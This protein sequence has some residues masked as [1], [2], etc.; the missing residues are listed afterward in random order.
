M[1]DQ[2]HFETILSGSFTSICLLTQ[3]NLV[4]DDKGLKFLSLRVMRGFTFR[5]AFPCEELENEGNP[6]S[7][8]A[9]RPYKR[10]ML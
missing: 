1:P 5:N 9:G 4:Q 3:I 6:T 7:I 2:Y 10:V 8:F